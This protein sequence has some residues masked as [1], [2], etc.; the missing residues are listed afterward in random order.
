MWLLLVTLMAAVLVVVLTHGRLSQLS[1]L[2]VSAIWLLVAGLAIQ[3]A[4]EYINFPRNQIETVGYGLLMVSYV[5]ILA[6][7]VTN[8]STRGFGVIAIGIAMNA[9]VIG[10]NQGMATKPIGS[11]A[12]GNRVLDR[13]ST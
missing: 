4:L 7:C 10:L 5:L 6:F 8:L 3:G 1:R 9:L 11:D 13:K 12:Q 2:R